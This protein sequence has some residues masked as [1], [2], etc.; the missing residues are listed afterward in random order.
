VELIRGD[1]NRTWILLFS[2]EM[3]SASLFLTISSSFAMVGLRP[4]ISWSVKSSDDI[5]S[6]IYHVLVPYHL[7]SGLQEKTQNF[8]I[9]PPDVL[10]TP[11]SYLAE[12]RWTE[13]CERQNANHAAYN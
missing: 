6:M 7:V 11:K 10:W 8:M 12:A 4:S 1:F 3:L 2:H 5:E 9:F 13:S